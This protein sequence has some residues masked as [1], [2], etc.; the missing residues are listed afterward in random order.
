MS[1]PRREQQTIVWDLDDVLNRF[2]ETWF[3][4]AWKVEHPECRKE[5]ADLRSHPPLDELGVSRSAYLA[6]IDT[7]RLSPAARHLPPQPALLRWFRRT[8]DRFRHVVLT[9]R[10]LRAVPPAAEWVF[11]HFGPWVRDFHF[12]PSQRPRERLPRYDGKKVD[13]LRRLGGVDYFVDDAR[14]NVAAARALG[15]RAFL[16]PQPWN[17]GAPS[18]ATIL[19]AIASSLRRT[20]PATPA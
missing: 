7:F 1:N 12:V 5:F 16:F 18:V 17:P 3:R 19:A 11:T 4:L 13:V 6:S 9:A 2:T 10:P 8:G 14:E 15:I 20:R